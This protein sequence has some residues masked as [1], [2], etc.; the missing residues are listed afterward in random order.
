MI[1]RLEA[2]LRALVE[3][4]HAR[5][6][7]A[8]AGP[9][10]QEL[11]DPSF[12]KDRLVEVRRQSGPAPGISAAHY[13]EAF[14]ELERGAR[15]RP[16]QPFMPHSATASLAQ[17]ALSRCVESRIEHV[18]DAIPHGDS[19]IG[20]AIEQVLGIFR[21][22]GPCDPA[23]IQTKI[24]EGIALFEG[25]PAFPN[26]P[27]P[28]ARLEPNARLIV[29]GDWGTGVLGAIKVGQQMRRVLDATESGRQCHVVHLGDIYYSGWPEECRDRFLRYWP[30]ARQDENVLSW[31]LSG[32]H[33]MYSGGH[34]YFDVVLRDPRFRGHRLQPG[35][36]Q[37]CSS[38]FSLENDHWQV[39]GLDTGYKDHDLAG[40]QAQWVQQKL[41]DA[42]H[43]TMLMSHH[44]PFSTFEDVTAPMLQTLRSA[45]AVRKLD[46]WLWGHEHRAIAYE[47][48]AADYL[49]YGYCIGHG[50][51][52]VVM[53]GTEI[54]EHSEVEWAFK[55]ALD[56][57][58]TPW[59]LHGFAIVDFNGPE[60]SI[61]FRD[62][63]GRVNYP[64]PATQAAAPPA[65]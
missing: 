56:Q 28:P 23:W 20:H 9:V 27:A 34:G 35:S 58:G 25:R 57:G 15:E 18:L 17:S 6:T 60:F 12:V 54:A 10:V 43:R 63:D 44:Q 5:L 24:A 40:D 53:T 55:E 21:K 11:L 38:H 64:P 7:P 49:D 2:H 59:G 51:V 1:E 36:A 45:F 47:K 39:L 26:E 19:A 32:N 46:A 62:E 22:F 42:E 61:Q 50:G 33:D 30:V 16:E 65:P 37:E 48:G 41:S 3:G 13:E 8:G 4:D 29:V 31:T 14:A 52:P